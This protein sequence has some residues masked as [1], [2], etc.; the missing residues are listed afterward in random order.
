MMTAGNGERPLRSVLLTLSVPEPALKT[1]RTEFPDVLFVVP[2]GDTDN[3]G[4]Y[5]E[6][7]KPPTADELQVADAVIGWNIDTESLAHATQLR[8]VHAASAGVEQFDAEAFRGRNIMLTNSRGVS[9][10]NMAEHVIGM[11]I[12][13]A[14]RFP[15]LV[16]AQ[17]KREWRDDQTHR[18]VRELQGQTAL[19]VGTGEIGRAIA[20]RLAAFAMRVHGVRRRPEAELPAG[21]DAMFGTDALPEALAGADHVIVTLPDT[22][23]TRGFVGA[24]AFAAMRDG[25][26][27]YNVGRGPVIDSA[28]MIAALESGRLGGAGLDVTDPE[29][30]PVESPLWTMDNVLI[31]AHTS[32]ATP[33]HWERLGALIADNIRLIQ[34]GERPRNLVDLEA[35]Y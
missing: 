28:A 23:D 25:T 3:E 26:M 34:R 17:A 9:A 27:I 5:R 13:L 24:S 7:P 35:G 1:L 4:R 14:R 10:P 12:A 20:Q 30:L 21:F 2:G 33:R 6:A 18:E 22:P 8:W 16:Q 11:M 19:I 15:S 32:G 29:P 31:T